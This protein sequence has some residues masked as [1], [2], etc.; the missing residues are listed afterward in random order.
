MGG[1]VEHRS[2]ITALQWHALSTVSLQC[3]ESIVYERDLPHTDWIAIR[4]G[5]MIGG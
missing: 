1:I 2:T 3:S 5:K 4:N